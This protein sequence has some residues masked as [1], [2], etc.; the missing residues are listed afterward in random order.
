M[1]FI[2][3]FWFDKV[4]LSIYANRC[5]RY[6]QKKIH[7]LENQVA[8]LQGK[9][10]DKKCFSKAASGLSSRTRTRAPNQ[11]ANDNA[12]PQLHTQVM[13]MK[14]KT[15]KKVRSRNELFEKKFSQKLKP[16]PRPPSPKRRPPPRPLL[17][18]RAMTKKAA[19][20]GHYL[21]LS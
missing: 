12:S 4:N 2:F 18:F 9:D 11:D 21:Y 17:S 16:Q 10:Q 6:D 8:V 13:V 15:F 7:R 1:A 19:P 20:A 5:A 3:F 14:K